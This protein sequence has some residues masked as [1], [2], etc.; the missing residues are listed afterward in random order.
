M[1]VIVVVHRLHIH[2]VVDH[3]V[4]EVAM[5]QIWAPYQR[6]RVCSIQHQVSISH[7]HIGR[8]IKEQHRFFSV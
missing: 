8:S 1:V 3:M 2:L 7:F 5:H 6:P 4:L